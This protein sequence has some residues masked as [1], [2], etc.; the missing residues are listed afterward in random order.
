MMQFRTEKISAVKNF[1]V[2]Q[3]VKAVQAFLGLTGFFRKFVPDYSKIAKP[4]TDLL[5]KDVPFVMNAC[6]LKAF[7]QLK[8]ELA[9]EPVLMLFNPEAK[10]ELH[11]DASKV[12]FGA[13]LMQWVE[14]KLHPVYYWSK[15]T[16][17]SEANKHSYILEAKAV[18]LAIKKLRQYL[19]G[20]PF[21]LVTD[22]AAFK[23]T[24]KKTEVPQEVLPWVMFLQ[25]FVFEAEHR[26]GKRMQH[27]DCLSRYPEE[28]MIVS[29]ELTARI[30]KNQQQDEMIRAISEILAD[31]PYG[32]YKSKGGLLYNVVDGND[33]LVIPRNMRKQIVDD[34]HN[35][36]H[37]GVQRT[38]HGIKQ[39]Y[40]ISHL[41]ILVKRHIAN[42]VK[43]I[44][45]NKKLGRQE[46]FLSPIDKGDA[47]LHTLHLDH[48][49]PM[50][51]TSKQYRYIL[52]M[53]DGFSKF[54][55]HYPTR[56]TNTEEVRNYRT[57]LP[58]L[59][60]R[61]VWLQIEEQHLRRRRSR[62]LFGVT[63]LIT[64]LRQRVYL[65]ETGRRSG[66]IERCYRSWANW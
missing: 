39:K 8:E 18:Y 9:K 17:E 57:G 30:R 50:D 23:S 35:E 22:C 12:G 11:T 66:S 5:K 61:H 27:V 7:Q 45:H 33:L 58:Y 62:S 6:A 2:P 41:E 19:L 52:T 29:S 16:S 64:L 10:T 54:V 25:D 65:V 48:L 28:V 31:R 43:C 36:G 63:R 56:T 4:L 38:I 49:G 44:L 34:A 3:N 13:A 14:G 53:V 55:W 20:L 46:G 37:Y 1:K 26:S 40:W 47:P 15:K 24:L 51:A 21:K 32:S 60:C 42:C 59:G